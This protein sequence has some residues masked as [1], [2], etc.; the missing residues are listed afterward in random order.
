MAEGRYV[1]TLT[2]LG[3]RRFSAFE[4]SEAERVKESMRQDMGFP[5]SH[6]KEPENRP[7]TSFVTLSSMTFAYDETG[8]R[9]VAHS[10]VALTPFGFANIT[11]QTLATLE[12]LGPLLRKIAEPKIN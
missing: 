1:K 12:G 11:E 7:K 9:W 4:S 6:P 8:H 5:P 10:E 3:F 2:E